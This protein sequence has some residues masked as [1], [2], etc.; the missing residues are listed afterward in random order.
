MQILK[1][2][3]GIISLDSQDPR[4]LEMLEKCRIEGLATG[5]LIRSCV[6]ILSEPVVLDTIKN[7]EIANPKAKT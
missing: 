2:Q 3:V 1:F 6:S 7:V 5:R 4:V